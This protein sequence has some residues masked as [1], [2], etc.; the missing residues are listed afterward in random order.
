MF[1]TLSSVFQICTYIYDAS[2]EAEMEKLGE[3]TSKPAKNPPVLS[4]KILKLIVHKISNRSHTHTQ[5][6]IKKDKEGGGKII[7]ILVHSA[8]GPEGRPTLNKDSLRSY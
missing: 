3:T 5:R 8:K 1:Q 2:S 7:A 6:S 4:T